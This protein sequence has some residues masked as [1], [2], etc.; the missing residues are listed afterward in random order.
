METLGAEYNLYFLHQTDTINVGKI[1]KTGKICSYNNCTKK[2]FDA[3]GRY[4]YAKGSVKLSKNSYT[5]VGP[6]I[7]LQAFRQDEKMPMNF[8]SLFETTITEKP[9]YNLIFPIESIFSLPVSLPKSR[10]QRIVFEDYIKIDGDPDIVVKADSIEVVNCV[11]VSLTITSSENHYIMKS[12]GDSCRFSEVIKLYRRSKQKFDQMGIDSVLM[13]LINFCDS[14]NVNFPLVFCYLFDD[15]F[16][17]GSDSMSDS[18]EEICE[19]CGDY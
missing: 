5:G 6:G 14:E 7:H 9:K 4:L 2:H 18:S 15:D 13:K 8:G 12:L 10:V 19:G 11:A 1:F 17:S 3:L 16:E